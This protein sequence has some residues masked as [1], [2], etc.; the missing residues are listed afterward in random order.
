VVSV[1]P[2]DEERLVGLASVRGVPLSRLGETGGPRAMID[3][4]LDIPVAEL[5]DVWEGAIPRLLGEA[6]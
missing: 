4:L 1:D 6:C 5:A 3:G 2:A